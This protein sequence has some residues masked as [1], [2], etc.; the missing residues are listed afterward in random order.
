MYRLYRDREQAIEKN[1]QQEFD[2]FSTTEEDIYVKDRRS[3]ISEFEFHY[4]D[5]HIIKMFCEAFKGQMLTKEDFRERLRRHPYLPT[6]EYGK[7]GMEV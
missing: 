4:A 3:G 5:E 6:N 7:K 1:V 2:L